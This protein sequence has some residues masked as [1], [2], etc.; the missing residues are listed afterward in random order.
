MTTCD[1]CGNKVN[2]QA[3]VCPHC[4]KRRIAASLPGAKPSKEEIIA[5]LAMQTSARPPSE[6]LFQTLLLPH[7][8]TSGGARMVELAC[9]VISLPLILAGITTFMFGRKSS[10][11]SRGELAPVI[12][13]T[14]F[15]TLGLVSLLGFAGVATGTMIAITGVSLAAL[16]TRGLIRA[17][18]AKGPEL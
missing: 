3:A 8:A 1:A 15:G 16:W 17:S 13:M 2:D 14:L 4:G 9:T 11:A 10:E 7:A 5:L 6:G 12:R 18:A